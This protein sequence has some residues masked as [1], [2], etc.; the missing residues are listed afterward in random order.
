M[1]VHEDDSK[2]ALTLISFGDSSCPPNCFEVSSVGILALVILL[3]EQFL[4][5]DEPSEET[6]SS[7]R[8]MDFGSMEFEFSV[9]SLALNLR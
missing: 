4:L 7:V 1:I 6:W 2:K 9:F 5:S 3:S 8:R